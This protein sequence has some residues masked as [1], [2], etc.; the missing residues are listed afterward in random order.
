MR[1]A[2]MGCLA[3]V[4]VVSNLAYAATLAQTGRSAHATHIDEADIEATV[5][6]AP[7]G[8][9]SDQQIRMVDAGGHNVG[10]GVVHRPATDNSS[11]IVHDQQTEVYQVLS[12]VGIMVTGGTL[13]DPRPLNPEGATVRQLTGPSSFGA[14]IEGGESRRVVAGDMVIVPAGVPH[15]FSSIAEPITYLVIRIDPDQVVDLK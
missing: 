12:G 5:D 10:I 6:A 7:R 15:G 8:R 3:L 13:I 4:V 2:M 14:G 9:V 11:A 1:R